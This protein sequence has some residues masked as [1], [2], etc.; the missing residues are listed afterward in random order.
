MRTPVTRMLRSG[1]LILAAAAL[2]ALAAA[3]YPERPVR[4]V[5]GVQAGAGTDTLTRQMARVMGDRLHQPFIVDNK[6]G[7][8]TRIAM[9]QIT[10]AQPD[11]YTIGVANAV[12][13]AFPLM[14]DN[15]DFAQGKDFIAVARLGRVP[16][17]LAVRASL[18]VRNVREFIAYAKANDGRLSFGHGGNGTNPHLSALLLM[19]SIGVKAIEVPYKGNAPTAVALAG[20]DVDFAMLDYSAVRPLVERGNVRL[21]AVTE[22]KRL[23]ATPQVPTG[24]EAGLTRDLDGMAPWFLLV[25]PAGTPAPVVESLSRWAREA[26]QL[27]EV[28][29][30]LEATGVEVDTSTPAEA[31]KFF[32]EQRALFARVVR[33]LNVSLKN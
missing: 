23:S 9:E 33:E 24:G 2:P 17:Y 21:L 31:Q 6:P 16:S 13:S 15:F 30:S 10:R 4:V 20:G 11:G 32:T 28:R 26:L 25:A 12:S 22:P 7:G 29:K 1:A 8:A 27:P 19:R 5:I 3:E 14:F 18:P